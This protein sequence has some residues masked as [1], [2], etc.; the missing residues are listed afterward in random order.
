MKTKLA[1]QIAFI[2]N[3]CDSFD[4]GN[5]SESIRIA[6]HLRIIFHDTKMSVSL[7]SHLG[8]R[9]MT[10]LSSSRG[11]GNQHDYL[12]Y[13]FTID[14]L[15]PAKMIPILDEKNLHE[16]LISHWWRGETVLTHNGQ[17]ITRA[18]LILDAA[19]RDGGAHVDKKLPSYYASLSE[20]DPIIGMAISGLEI[21]GKPPFTQGITHFAANTHMALIRQFGY[22]FLSSVE[23]L[24]WPSVK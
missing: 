15:E 10:I 11:H 1:E 6:L 21:D 4:R 8:M 19:N 14:S 24:S 23:R 20:G 17:N 2:K 13:S 12:S 3:S 5:E 16:I 9:Q 7:I 22:E 18:K